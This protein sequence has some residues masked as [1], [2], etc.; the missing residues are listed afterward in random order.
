MCRLLP[1]ALE[2]LPPET[3]SIVTKKERTDEWS[4]RPCRA[5]RH[6]GR[7]VAVRADRSGEAVHVAAPLLALGPGRGQPKFVSLA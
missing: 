1:S 6:R 5:V 7:N 3:E 2:Q 4:E